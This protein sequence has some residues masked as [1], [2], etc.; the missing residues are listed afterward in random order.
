[1]EFN[2]GDLVCIPLSGEMASEA[3]SAFAFTQAGS[4]GYVVDY[5]SA[6]PGIYVDWCSL[7]GASWEPQEAAQF[8]VDGKFL[9]PI[10]GLMRED[11][12]R[13]DATDRD[14]KAI[15][16]TLSHLMYGSDQQ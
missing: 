7:T 8:I 3:N 11:F 10:M 15:I 6:L 14:R 13:P 12:E 4:W 2:I 9:M 5:K 1:M 16:R